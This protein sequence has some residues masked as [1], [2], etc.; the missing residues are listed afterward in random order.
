MFLSVFKRKYEVDQK[1]KSVT[2]CWMIFGTFF[3]NKFGNLFML[4]S[5]KHTYLIDVSYFLHFL[6]GRNCSV[7]TCRV[8]LYRRATDLHLIAI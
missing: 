6:V 1:M 2:N 7:R 3:K 8:N 4:I 5:S